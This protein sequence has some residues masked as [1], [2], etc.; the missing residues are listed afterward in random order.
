MRAA[1]PAV[2]NDRGDEIPIGERLRDSGESILYHHDHDP[3]LLIKLHHAPNPAQRAK[4]AALPSLAPQDPSLDAR[5]RNFAWPVSCVWNARQEPVGVIIPAV[6]NARSVTALGNPKLRARLAAE[7]NWHF[8]HAVAANIAY[9]FECLHGQR[10][11]IGDVKPENILVDARALVTLVDCDSV[12]VGPHLCP[13]GSEGFTAPEWIGRRFSDAPR[14][15]NADRFGLAALLYQLLAGAHPWTGE[16]MGG[17]EP[18]PRDRLIASGDWPYRA[19]ARLRPIPGLVPPDCLSPELAALFRRAFTLG[20]DDPSARPSAAEWHAACC[21]ALADLTQCETSAHHH[22]DEALDECPWCARV[23]VGLPDPFPIPKTPVDPFAPLILAFERALT[24]GDTRMA[25]ELWRNNPVLSR[26]ADL[27][28]LTARMDQLGRAIDALDQFTACFRNGD[29]G[30][31]TRLAEDHPILQEATLFSLEDCDGL[32]IAQALEHAAQ[33]ALEIPQP[34]VALPAPIAEAAPKPLPAQTTLPELCY[35]LESGWH[36][37]RPARLTLTALRPFNC[38]NLVL[39]DEETG[40]IVTSIPAQRLRGKTC[41]AFDQPLDRA[42]LILRPANRDDALRLTIKDPA[43][44]L[45]S[46]GRALVGTGT[47][48]EESLS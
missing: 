27:I 32:T 23:A 30:T 28:R 17:G 6:A 3:G 1:K 2:Y 26:T 9:L 36:G 45:R 12:Q 21:L 29:F 46:L 22:H 16:W 42:V 10:I 31:A 39:L 48:A 35:R 8:L 13:V 20:I 44:R 41:I 47:N 40:Q 24:R 14:D 7:L 4:L 5:H 38:P 43:K 34:P 33:K 11:V 37:L 19:G 25:V 18:P 15:V